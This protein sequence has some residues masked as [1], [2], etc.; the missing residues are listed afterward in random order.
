MGIRC[1]A[2][3]DMLL[4]GAVM[5]A[6]VFL[7]SFSQVMLKKSAG[8]AHASMVREYVNPLVIGAYGIFLLTTLTSIYALQVIPLYVGAVLESSNYLFVT[9]FGWYYF[10]ERL[11]RYK[12]VGLGIIML[13]I[14]IFFGG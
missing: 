9:F 12:L 1:R 4:H 13:G 10:G 5:L 3:N 14:L 11:N 6:G 2:M 8:K 7:A